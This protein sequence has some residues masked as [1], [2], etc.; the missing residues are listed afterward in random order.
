M[1]SSACRTV[2]FFVFVLFTLYACATPQKSAEFT[3]YDSGNARY[4]TSTISEDFQRNF[5]M[6]FKPGIVLIKTN[7]RNN[8]KFQ[9]QEKIFGEFA[10]GAEER[11]LIYVIYSDKGGFG[12]GY[13]IKPGELPSLVHSKDDF[14]VYLI[15]K[16]GEI[17]LNS[18]DPVTVPE[19]KS[20]FPLRTSLTD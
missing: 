13:H 8:I 4:S 15:S 11:G 12:D 14:R 9:K 1:K 20:T 10:G 3:F 5:G 2:L 18:A 16:D 17:L 6:A 7:G 19:L